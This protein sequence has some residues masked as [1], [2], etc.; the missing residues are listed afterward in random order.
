MNLTN[1]NILRISL[2]IATLAM[3]SIFYAMDQLAQQGQ[4]VFANADAIKKLV[5]KNE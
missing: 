3:I 2:S 5:R 4:K 1:T